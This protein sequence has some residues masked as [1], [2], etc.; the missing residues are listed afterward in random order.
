MNRV[1]GGMTSL[2]LLGVLTAGCATVGPNYKRP[3]VDAPGVFRG[4]SGEA[5]VAATGVPPDASI[6]DAQWETMFTDQPLRDLIATGLTQ[7]YDLQIAAARML[8]TEALLGMARSNQFPAV[9]AEAVAQGQRSSVGRSDAEARTAGVVQ[10]GASAGWELDFWGK[11]RRA[12]EAARAQVLASEWGR[13]AVVTSLVSRVATGY[14][15]LLSLDLELAIATR[16]LGTREESLGITR[17]RE[18]GGATSL[19]D[20]RQAEQL[21]YGARAAIVDVQRLIEQQQNF[22]SVL[23]GRNPGPIP[24]G[25]PLTEATRASE[26][27]AGLRRRCSNDVQTSSKP[28]S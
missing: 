1:S 14:Y 18:S 16:T 26:V 11:Y 4:A 15:A 24:R 6:A 17:I 5:G 20:V 10:L 12:T 23:L 8:Q 2:A 13:R 9:G 22:L 28:S 7:N 3:Q 19:V 25:S 27:P 21:V